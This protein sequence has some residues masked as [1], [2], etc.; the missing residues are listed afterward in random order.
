M[1]VDVLP[2]AGP[3]SRA[4]TYSWPESLGEPVV[5]MRVKV[6]LRSLI[7]EGW[8][9]KIGADA[10]KYHLKDVRSKLGPG[11]KAPLVDLCFA[12]GELYRTSP[13]Y[14]LQMASSNEHV[15]RDFRYEVESPYLM[16]YGPYG[17]ADPFELMEEAV[18]P[19]LYWSPSDGS[20]LDVLKD[21]VSSY[22]ER[23][24]SVVV[25][26]PN[27]ARVNEVKVALDT[28]GCVVNVYDNDWMNI[29]SCQSCQVVIGP[30]SAVMAPV[31]NA[32]AL[33]V[34]D[35]LDRSMREQRTPFYELWDIAKYRA[36]FEGLQLEAVT[37]LPP[38]SALR[39]AKVMKPPKVVMAKGFARVYLHNTSDHQSYLEVVPKIFELSKKQSQGAGSKIDAT[40]V[41]VFN[42]KGFI[43]RVRCKSCKVI[44]VCESCERPLIGV[45]GAVH[46][47]L[48]GFNRVTWAKE[49]ST[50][51]GLFCSSCEI[52]VPPV[53]S[54]CRSFELASVS[55]GTQKISIEL[56]TVLGERATVRE[57][58][59]LEGGDA[60]S[61]I[62]IVVATESVLL[63]SMKAAAVLF[64]DFD[65]FIYP[66]S[67]TKTYLMYLFS[68]ASTIVGGSR[69]AVHLQGRYMNA[70]FVQELHS[71]KMVEY[72]RRLY[73][74]RESFGLPPFSEVAN[75]D[76]N[77]SKE[78]GLY[79]ESMNPDGADLDVFVGNTDERGTY[80]SA[81]SR[82]QLLKAVRSFEQERGSRI[83]RLE[84]APRGVGFL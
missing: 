18:R 63:G 60:Q 35:P 81:S 9:V 80:I 51:N 55:K 33:V 34:V 70:E 27:F 11:P 7:Q 30:R 12:L 10:S 71:A 82:K 74:E 6:P 49:R 14:F 31:S 16:R 58:E 78:F 36:Q 68:R 5:G 66:N 72:L 26:V 76:V 67:E 2:K 8:I 64:L 47:N 41:V 17:R 19:V 1:N 44:Q 28:L 22:L 37:T 46:G 69:G 57:M 62:D 29:A 3:R 65:Q 52:T 50:L 56:Q 84:L 15:A 45:T 39:S 23:G 75:V 48:E 13:A 42:Q 73:K 4:L 54:G 40:L 38:L 61:P 77:S 21:R 25:I 24:G 79:L 43:L 83:K 53:C 59:S 32:L 20:L